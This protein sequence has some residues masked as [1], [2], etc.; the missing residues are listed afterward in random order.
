MSSDEHHEEVVEIVEEDSLNYIAE[1]SDVTCTICQAEFLDPEDLKIHIQQLHKGKGTQQCYFCPQMYTDL[2]DFAEHFRD[3]HLANLFYCMY[4]LRSFKNEK[5]YKLHDKKH[6]RGTK[7]TYSCAM[8]SERYGS[9]WDLRKHDLMFHEDSDEGYVIQ[10]LLPYL[11]A[12]LKCKAVTALLAHHKPT[13]HT[14]MSCHYTT[15][16]LDDIIEHSRNKKCKCYVCYKCTNVY[17]KKSALQSHLEKVCEKLKPYGRVKCPDCKVIYNSLVFSKHKKVCNIIICFTCGTQYPS[18]YE[19][20]EHQSKDHPLSIELATCKFCWKQ[21]VGTVALDKHIERTHKPHLHLYKYLCTYC[22]MP[23]NHPQKLFAHYF[24]MHKDIEPYTCKICSKKFRIR[25]QFTLHIKLEHKSIGFVE[26]DENYHVFFT[27]KKSENPFIPKSL[28][29]N[30]NEKQTAENSDNT[31]MSILNI[32]SEI[33]ET[34]GNQTETSLL[35][36]KKRKRGPAK[37]RKKTQN[38]IT[39][40]SSDDEPL[41]VLRK[42]T[43]PVQNTMVTSWKKKQQAINKKRFT[44]TICNKYCYTYQNYNHHVSLHSKNDYKKC[45]KCSKVFRSKEK[46]NR[47][48]NTEHSSSKL[49]DT[50]KTML[51]KRKKGESITDSLPMSERFRRTIKKVHC[52]NTGAVANIKQVEDGLSVQKFIENFMPEEN[53]SESPIDNTVTIKTVSGIEKKSTIKM[54]KF[55]IKPVSDSRRLAMPV[56]FKTNQFAKTLATI[57]LVQAVSYQE[58]SQDNDSQSYNEEMDRNESIPEVAEEVMLEGTEETPKSSQIPHKVVIPKLPTMYKDLRIAH[59]HPQAP[60]YKIVTVNEVLNAA[61][62]PVVK[63]EVAN[64]KNDTIKLPD[65]TK[66]VTTNPL[67]HLL[68]KT[69]IEKVMQPMKNKYYKC[70]ERNLPKMLAEALSNLD[71]PLV[72]KKKVIDDTFS[73]ASS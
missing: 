4:C 58:D 18:M 6:K 13:V 56:K 73:E 12:V 48:M 38:V 34:E 42:K 46:L 66:L 10:N 1:D 26:F 19:L 24:T 31:N 62:K 61:E 3:K 7:S 36:P 54:T 68:G 67:A 17:K 35:V 14:C 71:K 45:I 21:C 25:K 52:E 60:Y 30:E 65:G 9:L 29:E 39:I 57:R 47:H 22:K 64:K 43:E 63:K 59:L 11:S 28:Y 23:F 20:T 16:E 53:R 40:L 33:S 27:E 49:T 15:T 69:P 5:E 50:L 55:N 2:M 8:C 37:G 72:R 41:E 32:N 51:E 70:K 44:C